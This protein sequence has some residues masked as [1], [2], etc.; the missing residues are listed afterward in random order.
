MHGCLP[1]RLDLLLHARATARRGTLQKHTARNKAARAPCTQSAALGMCLGQL[2]RLLCRAQ[3]PK[4]QPSR[5]D[6][7]IQCRTKQT[8][9]H[10]VPRAAHKHKHTHTHAHARTCTRAG[11]EQAA[12][13]QSAG[14]AGDRARAGPEREA[15]A[16]RG[17]RVGPGGGDARAAGWVI[18][19]R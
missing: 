5:K 3:N 17:A 16:V 6:I 4:L 9:T 10:A 15:V 11:A 2:S 14:A 8:N 7:T 19:F 18:V 13:E 1:L 12:G